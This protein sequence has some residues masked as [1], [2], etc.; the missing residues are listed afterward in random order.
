MYHINT[1]HTLNWALYI[2]Y[3]SIKKLKDGWSVG[4]H[5]RAALP[6]SHNLRPVLGLRKWSSLSLSAVLSCSWIHVLTNTFVPNQE[7]HQCPQ[8]C[9]AVGVCGFYQSW[10]AQQKAKG[11]ELNTMS[12]PELTEQWVLFYHFLILV[13]ADHFR[14]FC[15]LSR[16][17]I[18]L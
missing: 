14:G 12:E 4:L 2:N 8:P 6:A 5:N 1:L 13:K 10:A 18:I 11:K 9:M 17:D 3:S 7:C 16:C 15:I